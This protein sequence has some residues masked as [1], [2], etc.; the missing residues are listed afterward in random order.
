MKKYQ[1]LIN[2]SV[3]S[4]ILII[5]VIS[6]MKFTGNQS[7]QLLI[8]IMIAIFYAIWGILHHWLDKSLH[9]KVVIEYLLISAIA[10]MVLLVVLKV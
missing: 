1:S 9:R 7:A 3:L 5:G 10:I 8:G 6:F 4:V 2:I